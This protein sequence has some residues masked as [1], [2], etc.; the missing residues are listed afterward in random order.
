MIPKL[1]TSERLWVC[2]VA[3]TGLCVPHPQVV[4]VDGTENRRFGA[5]EWGVG[6]GGECRLGRVLERERERERERQTDR[7]TDRVLYYTRIKM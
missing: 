1:A 2:A 7:Q 4:F 5:G 3:D 6:R